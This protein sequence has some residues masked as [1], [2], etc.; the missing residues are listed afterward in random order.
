MKTKKFEKILAESPYKDYF[1]KVDKEV[2]EFLW[3]SVEGDPMTKLPIN[4]YKNIRKKGF[5]VIMHGVGTVANLYILL[6]DWN[7]YK[8]K[9]KGETFA[10]L[11]PKVAEVEKFLI[12]K[13]GKK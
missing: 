7:V 1:E 9:P 2:L 11:M 6:A 3:S 8:S 13:G 10:T 4:A 5:A 12:E